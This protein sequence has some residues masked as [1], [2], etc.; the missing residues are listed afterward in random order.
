MP[1]SSVRVCTYLLHSPVPLLASRVVGVVAV[2]ACVTA[3][4]ARKPTLFVCA[5]L[6]CQRVRGVGAW[7]QT[8][9][10]TWCSNACQG[11]SS[12]HVSSKRFA[13]VCVRQTETKR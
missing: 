3:V 2:G 4:A 5:W 6:E 12:C 11:D 10:A 1:T 9:P 13:A 7:W 8:P